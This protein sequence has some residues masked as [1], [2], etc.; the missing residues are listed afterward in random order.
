MGTWNLSRSGGKYDIHDDYI[1]VFFVKSFGITSG[2]VSSI[3]SISCPSWVFLCA[4]YESL[5][6]VV[7]E[8]GKRFASPVY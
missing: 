1:C 6:V 2:E 4:R 8:G 7:V 5:G 3:N